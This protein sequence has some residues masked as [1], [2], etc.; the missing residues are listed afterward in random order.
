MSALY[1]GVAKLFQSTL[2]VRR[3]TKA[4]AI[5]VD[6]LAAFQSTLSVRR[7]TKH[8]N[9]FARVY[10]FQSTLSVRRATRHPHKVQ[11]HA[12]NFNPRSP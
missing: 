8:A 5:T 7:A 12:G 4:N 1:V 2:S 9:A 11:T 10:T 3:A 6:K